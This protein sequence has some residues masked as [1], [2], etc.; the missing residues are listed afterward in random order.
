MTPAQRCD[1]II[2]MIDEVLDGSL[3]AE[4]GVN[5]IPPLVGPSFDHHFT[6]THPESRSHLESLA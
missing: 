3:R 6:L 5:P 1:E 4:H 2:R